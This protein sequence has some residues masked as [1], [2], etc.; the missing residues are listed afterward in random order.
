MYRNYKIPDTI[1]FQAYM[2]STYKCG[3]NWFVL[4]Q[5]LPSAYKRK[6]VVDTFI[7]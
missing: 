3:K 6:Y 2:N 4:E 7:Q 1:K 5:T